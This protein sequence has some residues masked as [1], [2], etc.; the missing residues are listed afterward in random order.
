MYTP[1]LTVEYIH[2]QSIQYMSLE[3]EIG[4]HLT[5]IVIVVKHIIRGISDEL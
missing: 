4:Y 5:R 2:P 1:I 3:D